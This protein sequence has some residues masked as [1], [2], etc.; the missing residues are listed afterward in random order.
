[1][2]KRVEEINSVFGCQITP[3]NKKEKLSHE[4][5]VLQKA[6]TQQNIYA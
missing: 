5:Q 2:Y 4:P 1:M 3:I 6:Y